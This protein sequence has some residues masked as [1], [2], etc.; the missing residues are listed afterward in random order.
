MLRQLF[1]ALAVVAPAT[2]PLLAQGA[3]PAAATESPAASETPNDYTRDEAWL[4]RPGR[5]DA[6]AI[7]HTTTV[8]ASDGTMTREAW[9]ARPEGARG[10]LL[11]LPDHL[12]RPRGAERHDR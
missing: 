11:R 10:L 2:E 3:A 4:C 6:C 9:A 5:N 7:D 1:F 8:V 12:H